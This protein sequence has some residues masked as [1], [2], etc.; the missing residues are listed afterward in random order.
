MQRRVIG[1]LGRDD[2][3][4]Q[5]RAAQATGQ[6]T[7]FRRPGCLEALLDGDAGGV[8]VLAGVALLDGAYDEEAC[9]F[10]VQLLGRLR[11]NADTGPAT[12]RTELLR[13]R[14][15]MDDLASW[16]VFGQGRAAVGSGLAGLVLLGDRGNA[17]GAAAKAV[18]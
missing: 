13:L 4:Q 14:Q 18:L 5:A 17:F 6:G 7:D 3:G 2:L 12:A 1:K 11:A 9:R 10:Q 15:V 16:Q 8:A